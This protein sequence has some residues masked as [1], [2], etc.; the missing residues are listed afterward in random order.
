MGAN[1][2][3]RLLHQRLLQGDPVAPPELAEK[4]LMLTLKKVRSKLGS[5]A[6]Q[7]PTII[8]DAA[9]DAILCYAERPEKYN[10]DRLRLQS[11]LVMVAT[12]DALNAWQKIKRKNRRELSLADVEVDQRMRN[13][14]IEANNDDPDRPGLPN[15]WKQQVSNLFTDLRDHEVLELIITGERR[16]AVFAKALKLGNLTDEDTR[17]EV[18]RHKDRIKKRLNRLGVKWRA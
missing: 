2:D 13:N 10:P 3:E 12:A 1:H 7:E 14:L 4:Y 8:E 15:D 17:R 6:V 18:K 11:Y 5:I 16:T 9:I